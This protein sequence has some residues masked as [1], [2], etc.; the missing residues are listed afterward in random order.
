M[1]ASAASHESTHSDLVRGWKS[2]R[3][4]SSRR[5]SRVPSSVVTRKRQLPAPLVPTR[6]SVPP[7]TPHSIMISPDSARSGHRHDIVPPVM[8]P[9]LLP[10]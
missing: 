1:S 4:V 9:M 8:P 3:S 5:S 6:V 10:K 2:T 7:S